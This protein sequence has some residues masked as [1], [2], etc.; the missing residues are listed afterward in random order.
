MAA[1]NPECVT[2]QRD[3]ALY[4]LTALL[5]LLMDPEFHEDDEDASHCM[6]IG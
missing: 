3:A 2:R 4:A 1:A 5:S 6:G